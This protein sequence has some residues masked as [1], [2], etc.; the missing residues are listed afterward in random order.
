MGNTIRQVEG[1]CAGQSY[2]ARSAHFHVFYPFRKEKR[3]GLDL[4]YRK[5]KIGLTS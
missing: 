4:A 1:V 3:Q 5:P 2:P